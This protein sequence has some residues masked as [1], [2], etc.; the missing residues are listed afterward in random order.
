[1]GHGRINKAYSKIP[2][3]GDSYRIEISHFICIPNQLPDFCAVRVSAKEYYWIDFHWYSLQYMTKWTLYYVVFLLKKYNKLLSIF[4]KKHLTQ[5]LFWNITLMKNSY[6]AFYIPC[7][8][9]ILQKQNFAILWFLTKLLNAK[10]VKISI[11]ENFLLANVLCR[12][13]TQNCIITP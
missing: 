10:I 9:K 7:T 1:M 3:H 8:S 11:H 2:F 6:P 12:S 4:G 13:Y 5:S